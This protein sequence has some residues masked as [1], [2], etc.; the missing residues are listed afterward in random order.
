MKK[1][2]LLMMSL[3][4]VF[5]AWQLTQ[6]KQ[7][8]AEDKVK[9]VTTFYPVYEFT[10]GVIGN[11][12][13]VSMLMKAGTEPHDFEPSTKD[14]KK[15]QDA[16]A[17]VYMDDNMETWVSDV[18]KSL[19]SKKVTIVKGT[20]NMLLVAGAGH[21]HHHEDADKKHEH[22]KHSEEGHNHAFDPH[23]WLSPYRLSLIH[24]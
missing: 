7:V 22:N 9:V 3:I 2:I 17:F 19:T 24:I 16:D 11:D 21:D 6:A 4:S 15:I 8:L 14:I 18:K 23:V 13:D 20:G 12:G 5:F 10:K 1:K